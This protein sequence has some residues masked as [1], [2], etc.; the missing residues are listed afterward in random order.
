MSLKHLEVIGS[1]DGLNN[2][3]TYPI[4]APNKPLNDILMH[5]ILQILYGYTNLVHIVDITHISFIPVPL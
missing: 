1:T 4:A 5:N 2:S 3:H